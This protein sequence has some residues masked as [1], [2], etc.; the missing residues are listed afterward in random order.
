VNLPWQHITKLSKASES[1]C[2]FLSVSLV[3]ELSYFKFRGL[4]LLS[5]VFT[6]YLIVTGWSYGR[7][8]F[9]CKSDGGMNSDWCISGGNH[10]HRESD[11]REKKTLSHGVCMSSG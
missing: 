7:V 6:N 4:P 10:S 9:G 8:F 2:H 1:K 5:N 11:A 3:L